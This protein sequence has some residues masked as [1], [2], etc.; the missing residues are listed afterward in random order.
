MNTR[1]QY[2]LGFFGACIFAST[3]TMT[4]IFFV[5]RW[6]TLR[7]IPLITF[8]A[9]F[10]FVFWWIRRYRG[11]LPKPTRKQLSKAAKATKRL[12]LI[13]LIGP[14]LAYLL[15]GNELIHL[16][17]GLGFLLPIFPLALA[18]HNLRLSARLARQQGSDEVPSQS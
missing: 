13:Y 9:L 16:P 11:R 1:T 4:S 12:G 14:V 7:W 3:I 6:P 15:D 2:L 18:V 8:L 5:P 17:Y 10:I